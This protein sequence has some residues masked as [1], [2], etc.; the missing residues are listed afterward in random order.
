MGK[1]DVQKIC[2]CLLL[3]AI[4]NVDSLADTRKPSKGWIRTGKLGPKPKR[5]T[6]AFPLSDQ[7]NEGNWIKYELMSDEFK[8]TELDSNK[9]YPKNPG[10]LGRQPAYFYPGNVKV[11][12]GKLHLTMRK[13]EVPEMP[14]DKGYHTYTSAAVQ[15]KT[16]VKYGY[17]EVKC[18]PMKSHGSSSFWFYDNTPEW[19]IEIDV[20]EIGGGAPGFEKKYNMNVHVFRTPIEKKHWSMHG[21]WIAPLN[22]AD[23]Y[24]IYGLEWDKDKIKWYF[25]GVPVRR[26]ENTHWHQPLTLNFDSETMPKWFGLPKDS[27]LPST[28]SI[29]YVRAWKKEVVGDSHFGANL[30]IY[31]ATVDSREEFENIAN[32]L[33]PGD[34]LILHGGVYSQSARRAVTA[35]GTA[36][37]PIIIRA[38]EGEKP[39][40]THP[41]DNTDKYNNIEFVDCSYLVVRGICFKGGSSGVRFIRGHHITFEECEIFETG[42]NALTMNSGDCDAFIIRRNHIHHTGL[43]KSGPTEG[44]GM[45]IGVHNGSY[46]TTNTLIEGNYIHHLCGTSNGGNDGIEIKFGSYGNIVRDNVIHDTN[47]GRN[48][49]GIFVYGGGKWTNI[50]EGNVIWNAGEGIQVVSDAIIRNNIISNCSI[51]GITAAPHAAL[52]HVRNVKIVNNTIVN[53][54]QGVL[55]RWKKASDM[56]FANNA[57]YCPEFTAIDAQGIG[58]A[59]FSANYV[60]GRLVG[61]KID[62]SRFCDGGA[63][64]EAFVEPDKKNYWPKQG[65]VLINN[66]S[67]DFIAHLDFN[68]TLREPPFDVGAYESEGNAENPGLQ[69]QMGFK[70]TR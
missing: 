30:E 36:D 52:P 17:F 13:Q 56:V 6:D 47:I 61:V 1:K 11:S 12:D 46:I 44:E 26:V 37:E 39:L 22:L 38:A 24:H 2:M 67:P 62:S 42:N 3:V 4:V 55:I 63:V 23:D 51:T 19:W 27:D 40:L 20:F 66:A 50:V 48:Y 57:I 65:S 58:N 64:C 7:A 14:K 28:Y 10:W 68:H 41:A 15:S 25:D 53:H 33:K 31:P 54:P 8:G 5:I 18:R 59:M 21:E 32:S 49:P 69:V 29:E 60:E 70:G 34:E 35:K 9:W 43:S 45:Y 16:K